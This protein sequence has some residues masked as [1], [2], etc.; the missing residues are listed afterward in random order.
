MMPFQS[1][2][3]FLEKYNLKNFLIYII[4]YLGYLQFLNQF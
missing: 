4:F 2:F 3:F 1:I